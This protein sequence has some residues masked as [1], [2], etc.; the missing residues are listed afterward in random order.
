MVLKLE[1]TV[2]VADA[3]L[4]EEICEDLQEECGYGITIDLEGVDFLGHQS[5]SILCRLQDKPDLTLRGMH[6]FVEQIINAAAAE[7]SLA[8]ERDGQ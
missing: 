6:L 2:T 1:G 5:A 7:R 4:L 3:K 8:S